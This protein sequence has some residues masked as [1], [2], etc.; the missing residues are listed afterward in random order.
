MVLPGTIKASQIN[1]DNS[2]SAVKVVSSYE[3]TFASTDW[4]GAAAPYSI[5]I[6]QSTHGVDSPKIVEVLDSDGD[7]AGINVAISSGTVTLSAEVKF[8]GKAI[9]MGTAQ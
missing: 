3:A 5:A 9:I 7:M 6:A 2:G 4:T 1:I 8:A